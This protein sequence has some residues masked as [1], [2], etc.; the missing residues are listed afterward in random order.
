MYEPELGFPQGVQK[1]DQKKIDFQWF[2]P[3]ESHMTLSMALKGEP[4]DRGCDARMNLMMS[5]Y[6]I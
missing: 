5:F 2:D 3:N 4:L 1:K 6:F